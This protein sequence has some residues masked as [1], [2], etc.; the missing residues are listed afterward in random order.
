M[1]SPLDFFARFP[2]FD[3]HPDAPI[4]DEFKRLALTRKWKH[5]SRRWKRNW[6]LCMKA[7]Y[8]SLIGGQV[9]KLE[10]WQRMC[11]KVGLDVF[12]SITKCKKVGRPLDWLEITILFTFHFVH[13]P[14]PR[15]TSISSTCLS[16]GRNPTEDPN[17]S[18]ALRSWPSILSTWTRFT[19]ATLRR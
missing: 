11:K 7:K 17:A 18:V 19:L 8:R 10:T 5:R 6:N 1:D 13:R 12:P 9:S 14:C 4:T 2:E 15:S 3:Y 16:A